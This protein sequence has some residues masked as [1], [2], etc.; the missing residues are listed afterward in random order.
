M[1]TF[2]AR[3]FGRGSHLLGVKTESVSQVLGAFGKV[4][5]LGL[6]VR[7]QVV[8]VGEGLSAELAVE[9][10][11]LDVNVDQVIAEFALRLEDF[12]AE[13]AAFGDVTIFGGLSRRGFGQIFDDD[14]Q[15]IVCIDCALVFALFLFFNGRRNI[16]EPSVNQPHVSDVRVA[17]GENFDA[18]FA[19]QSHV[20]NIDFGANL[21]RRVGLRSR[22]RSSSRLLRMNHVDVILKLE[23]V[24]ELVVARRA[25]DQKNAVI[26]IEMNVEV[27]FSDELFCA[28]LTAQH[29]SAVLCVKVVLSNR[30]TD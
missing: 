1:A 6:R 8:L 25:S 4:G 5:V 22:T 30:R 16:E 24:Q 9:V 17:I 14:R 2:Q 23:H 12:L 28:H 3:L 7:V 27:A 11:A 19:L 20:R 15:R 18:V 29:L 10:E 13:V 21:F 26:R